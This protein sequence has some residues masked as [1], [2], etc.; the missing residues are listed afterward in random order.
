MTVAATSAPV[1]E[2]AHI[3]RNFF[4]HLIRRPL[5]A[6]SLAILFVITLA[7][8]LAPLLTTFGPLDQDLQHVMAMPNGHHLLG[9]DTLGRDVFSRL[10]FGGR[11]AL[12]GVLIA[13]I[14]WAILGVSVGLLSGYVGGAVDRVIS[15]VVDLG[16]SL[17]SIVIILAVLALFDRSMVAS[18]VAMGILASGG[19][20]RVVRA[21]TMNLREELYVSAAK[22]SGIGTGRILVR[23]ILPG[24]VGPVVI[25]VSIFAG[26]ALTIQTGLGFLDLGVPAP[27][28]SW[29]NMVGEAAQVIQ[30]FPWLLVPSGGAIAITI[31]AFG[32]IGDSARD[33]LAHSRQP[34]SIRAEA[35]RERL[36]AAQANS[37]DAGHLL[38]VENLVISFDGSHDPVVDGI[39]FEVDDG[40]VVGLVGE[41]GSGKTVTALSVLGLLASNGHLAATTLRLGDI[42]LLSLTE[43]QLAEIRGSQVAYISQ[44][45]MVALDP[46][47]TVGSLMSEVIRRHFPKLT[48]D[49]VRRRAVDLLEQV[50]L[51]N[52]DAL[53]RKYAFEL[54]GG[55]AQRVVIAMALAGEPRLLI[56]DEPT[57][58]L[59]VTVQAEILD[60]LRD[61]GRDLGMA[62]LLVT[63]DLGVVADICERVLVMQHGVVVESGDCVALFADP[64]HPYTQQLLA[65]TPNLIGA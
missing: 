8:I 64:K 12:L 1:P 14:C 60:L 13:V 22:V 63:H 54:S 20:T 25:Q 41:S 53:L 29:G 57:T 15:A 62:V 26:V 40:E 16:M 35:S 17:P 23:H 55:M 58:A 42:D 10:L 34:R 18:M 9:T 47:F 4:S 24:I 30:Q 48:R 37:A 39:S 50:Q 32:L 11:S 46:S 33:V 44:E 31:L 19:L 51:P 65:A 59:D 56:A 36:S 2:V 52:P 38:V 21:A 49:Q 43:R 3:E 5:G 6:V 7:S 45:P 28:P 61:L 27:A